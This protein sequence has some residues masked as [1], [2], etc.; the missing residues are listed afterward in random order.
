MEKKTLKLQMMIPS[1]FTICAFLF[2]LNGI[3]LAI[4]G[5]IKGAIFS[6]GVSAV[7][8]LLDGRVARMLMANRTRLTQRCCLFWSSSCIYCFILTRFL[9]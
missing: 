7:L 3:R 9:Q 2:G 4:L 6:I 5:D 1:L 8:D